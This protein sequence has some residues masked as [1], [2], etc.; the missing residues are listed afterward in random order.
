[1][2][3]AVTAVEPTTAAPRPLRASP[4]PFRN[5]TDIEFAGAPGRVVVHDVRG[6]LVRSWEGLGVAGSRSLRWDGTDAR[7]RAV[8][9]GIYF[10]RTVGAGS[11]EAAPLRIVFLH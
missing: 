1:M 10:V 7:G 8:A 4:N 5:A 9:S 2:T 11:R 3:S 6:R